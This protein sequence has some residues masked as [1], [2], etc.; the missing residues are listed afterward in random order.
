MNRRNFLANS[1]LLGLALAW[2]G[3][4]Q[5]VKMT[6][7]YTYKKDV[8]LLPGQVV[9]YTKGKG[10]WAYTPPDVLPP[11][12]GPDENATHITGV[13]LS[14]NRQTI[15]D[16]YCAG[17]FVNIVGNDTIVS[18]F[19]I[20]PSNDSCI[21]AED[22]SKDFYV[23]DGVIHGSGTPR[24]HTWGDH[25]F[26]ESGLSVHPIENVESYG[27]NY[28][29]SFSPR[30]WNLH[31]RCHSHDTPYAVGIFDYS[32]G[33]NEGHWVPAV[34]REHLVEKVSGWTFYNDT[35]RS[36]HKNGVIP[37]AGNTIP[38]EWDHCTLDLRGQAAGAFNFAGDP[39]D[40]SSSIT[41]SLIIWDGATNAWLRTSKKIV[42]AGN[43]VLTS[44]QAKQWLNADYT[45][46]KLTGS[47]IIGHAVATKGRA[48]TIWGPLECVGAFQV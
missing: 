37:G 7:Y 35:V 33:S 44:A 1:A 22:G 2:K 14:S 26:Y 15:Q 16:F 9:H 19:D 43:V 8:P 29:Q 42:T 30:W 25:G 10:Y 21:V 46:K 4:L 48:Q 39:V 45:P 24:L 41:N 31:Y 18:H 28:G 17:G 36:T 34:F 13:T 5:A 6:Q 23:H 12:P 40:G 20:G 38:A 11:H 3:D 32:D 47:P 27:H